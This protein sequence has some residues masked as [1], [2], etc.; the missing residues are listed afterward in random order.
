MAAWALRRSRQPYNF[1]GKVILITGG[2]RG[3]GLQMAREF[4]V[5]GA[6]IAICARNAEELDEARRDLEQRGIPVHAVVCDVT[7][8]HDVK[9]LIEEVE[10][11][12]GAIDVLVNNAGVIQVGP[13]E[14]MTRDDFTN[15]MD[16]I[17]WGSLNTILAVAPRMMERGKGRIVNIT[18]IG[19]KVSVPHLLPY[20]C[21][22][23]ATVALSEGLRTELAP[24]GIRVVTIVPG[25]MRTG[26]HLN[27]EFKGRQS[28]EYAW[29]SLGAA[30]PLVSIDARRAAKA[31]VRATEQGQA[32]KILSV[33]ADL[34]ARLHGAL[35]ELTAPILELV[36]RIALPRAAG[37]ESRLQPGREAAKGIHNRLFEVATRMGQSAAENLNEV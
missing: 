5:E 8:P 7:K 27:A 6:R 28:D 15:A 20:S 24:H 14:E 23:F 29:F 4:G 32:E 30:T 9:A 16:V 12:M 31:V 22:K 19:G 33:P 13:F 11:L 26:S 25:L 1:L 3:L 10:S 2:S 36:N 17:F 37:G 18:S 21:A 35:P 34:M